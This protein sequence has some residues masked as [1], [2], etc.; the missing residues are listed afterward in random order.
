[1]IKVNPL[2]KPVY[3]SLV[4]STF[5]YSDDIQKIESI[6]EWDLTPRVY[7]AFLILLTAR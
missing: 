3:V 5:L 4:G 1:M 6:N 2:D 7:V